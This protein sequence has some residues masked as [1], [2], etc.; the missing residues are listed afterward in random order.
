[1]S[2]HGN[3]VFQGPYSIPSISITHTDEPTWH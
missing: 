2:Q 3:F 1:L